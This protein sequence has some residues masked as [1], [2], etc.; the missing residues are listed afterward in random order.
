MHKSLFLGQLYHKT[1]TLRTAAFLIFSF[2]FSS[3][4]FISSCKTTK[5]IGDLTEADLT[6]KMVKGGCYGKCPIY[7]LEIYEG[8]YTKFY[9][10]R[11]SD[12]LGIYDKTISK[13]LYTDLVKTFEKA[14]FYSFAEN[15]ES[16]V[17]DAPVV[18][19][20]FKSK[21]LEMKEV[22]G[23]LERPEVLKELQ[24]LLENVASSPDWNLLEKYEP[25]EEVV[26]E[27][28]KKEEKSLIKSEIIIEPIANF[29]LSNW[30]NEKKKVY[31]VRIIRKIAPNLNLWVIGYDDRKVEG[32]MLLQILQ[33]DPN[34][35]S[36]EFNKKTSS[37]GN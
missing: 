1:T 10:D 7:T 12:K 28:S 35:L 4:L 11:H 23:K 26:E 14:D 34:I 13:E 3:S 27:E 2:L 29:P 37:R 19:I 20:G 31:G 15:Y 6:F 33:D 18:K 17:P 36:A 5:A 22:T 30:I 32:D 9:G 24:V 25:I 21:K 8:G 16:N